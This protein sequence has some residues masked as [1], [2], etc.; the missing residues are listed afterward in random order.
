MLVQTEMVYFRD[1]ANFFHVGGV[2]TRTKNDGD[3]CARVD[4][5]RS[6]KRSGGIINERS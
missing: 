3:F 2:A 1:L 5:M 6:D 4:V